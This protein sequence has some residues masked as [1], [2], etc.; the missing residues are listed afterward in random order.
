MVILAVGFKVSS[1]TVE[2]YRSSNGIEIDSSEMAST[3]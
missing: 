2:W 3:V 1:G